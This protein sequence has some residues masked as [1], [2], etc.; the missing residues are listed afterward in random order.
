MPAAQRQESLAAEILVNDQHGDYNWI[1]SRLIKDPDDVV[2]AL[3][4]ALYKR[5]KIAFIQ[6]YKTEHGG[7]E[8]DREAFKA[9]HIATDT[10]T[11]EA[12]FRAQ[13]EAMLQNFL[14]QVLVEKIEKI[15]QE[16]KES[17][18][19]AKSDSVEKN[20]IR[21]IDSS[22]QLIQSEVSKVAA[23][24]SER[25]GF[26]GWTKDLGANL[27]VNMLTVIIIGLAVVGLGALDTLNAY[28]KKA[29]EDKANFSSTSKPEDAGRH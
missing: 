22:K 9:F 12:S 11:A 18:L 17:V 6:A 27:L 7:T 29:M 15:E 13:A 4:Y 21:D 10:D 24:L 8:P 26:L 20:I 5:H 25:K 19:I 23:T 16:L 28:L 14:D 2:G 1:S 3:A